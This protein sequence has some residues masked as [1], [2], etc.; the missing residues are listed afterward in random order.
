VLGYKAPD[1]DAR[2]HQLGGGVTEGQVYVNF[3]EPDKIPD[4]HEF[5]IHFLDQSMDRRDNDLDSLIDGQD[6]DELLP[7]QTTGFELRDLTAND[8]PDTVWFFEKVRE[9]GRTIILKD[10]YADDDANPRTLTTLLRGMQFFI[11]NPAPAILNKPEMRI[12]NGIQW[13]RNIDYYSAYPLRFGIFDLGGFKKGISYPRQYKIVFYDEIVG[14]SVTVYP[15]LERTGTP[16]P[17]PPRDVNFKIYDQQT[18][19]EIPFG[20]V[21]ASTSSEIPA[22]FFSAKDRIFFFETL[23][24]SSTVITFSLLNNAVEDT[25][26]I[27]AHGG[28]L[29]AGDTLNL[30]P[31]FPFTANVR[32]RFRTRAQKVDLDDARASL[33]RITVVPNPYVVTAAWEPKNPYTTGRGPRSIKFM[34][35]P[36]D[37]TIRIYSVDGSLVRKLEHHSAMTDGIEEW[38][39]LSKDNMEIAFGVYVYHIEAPGIGEKV[40]RIIIIK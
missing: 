14:Q 2:P 34:N 17:V 21:D 22:G 20:F 19:E 18:G 12:F 3:V 23:P 40:G 15:I 10:L 7:T 26:F 38:D 13:S 30:Y 28:L 5:E 29:G 36:K 33:E 9:A 8:R 6:P 39:V 37:C 31:D 16:I 1:F 35:L 32:Y 4:G 11:Y 24:D 25:S 27:K